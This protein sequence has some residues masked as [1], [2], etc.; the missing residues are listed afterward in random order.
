MAVLR[1][2][3]DKYVWPL[4]KR[5]PITGDV[6]GWHQYLNDIATSAYPKGTPIWGSDDY[7][8]RI[9]TVFICVLVRG[10][11]LKSLPASVKQV[12]KEGSKV[13]YNHPS[14]YLIHDRPN[15]FMPASDFWKAVSA[16]IDIEANCFDIITYS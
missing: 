12:T 15:P 13:A 11:S 5:Y 16:R 6:N 2:F 9:A 3:I 10:E 8:I 1:D 7:A 4:E 14:H